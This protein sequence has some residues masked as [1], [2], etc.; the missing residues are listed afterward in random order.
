MCCLM[1]ERDFYLE[2]KETFPGIGK[3]VVTRK[4]KEKVKSVDFFSGKVEL[5][6]KDGSSREIFIKDLKREMKEVK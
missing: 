3:L 4:G 1:Y 5:I 2:C 6:M